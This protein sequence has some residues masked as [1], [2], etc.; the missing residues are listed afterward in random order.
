MTT[1]TSQ[2][3]SQDSEVV[4][5]H[6]LHTA[7]VSIDRWIVLIILQEVRKKKFHLHFSVARMGSCGTFVFH[8]ASNPCLVRLDG[9]PGTV[10]RLKLQG[11]SSIDRLYRTLWN[12]IK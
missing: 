10:I 8:T 7:E 3:C 12:G 6:G 4:Q 1:T 9:E 2:W 5:A 11:S